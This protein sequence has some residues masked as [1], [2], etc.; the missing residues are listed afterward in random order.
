MTEEAEGEREFDGTT[1]SRNESFER[2]VPIALNPRVER[3]SDRKRVERVLRG[4]DCDT[5]SLTPFVQRNQLL[6][7][8]KNEFQYRP[9]WAGK[10]VFVLTM[11][12]YMLQNG[13]VAFRAIFVSPRKLSI[14]FDHTVSPAR[15]CSHFLPVT[16]CRITTDESRKESGIF[17][18]RP[19]IE[20]GFN[21]IRGLSCK[22]KT[23]CTSQCWL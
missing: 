11:N 3:K 20:R 7:R 6:Q 8:P 2:I 12:L 13:V 4:G 23:I 16:E 15:S 5:R 10:V 17:S 19:I 14:Y 9:L 1:D 21:L 18:D 22:P